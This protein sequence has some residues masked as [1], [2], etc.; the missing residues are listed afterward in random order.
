[1]IGK[2]ACLIGGYTA[3]SHQFGMN[4]PTGNK[5]LIK[6]I[7]NRLKDEQSRLQ[8]LR[9]ISIDRYSMLISKK[10]IPCIRKIEE[11]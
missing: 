10:I 9:I 6:L 4:I 7:S 11:N 5:K 1:M 3:Y 2:S 8:N